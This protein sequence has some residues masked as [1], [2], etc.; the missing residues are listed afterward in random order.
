M[1][2][3]IHR[4]LIKEYTSYKTVTLFF[5]DIEGSTRLLQKLGDNYSDLLFQQKKIMEGEFNSYNGEISD[6][7]GDGFFVIFETA[8]DAVKCAVSIQQKV[9]SH[10]WPENSEV[11]IRMGI[12]TGEVKISDSGYSGI[13]IH[14]AARIMS[15][16]FGGQVL[17]SE[18]TKTL[19]EKNLSLK[20]KIKYL[21][22][23]QLKDLH[24]PEKIYQ[25]IMEGLPS[26]FPPLKSSV[27]PKTNLPPVALKLIGRE[28]EIESL[29]KFLTDKETRLVTITGPGGMG[30][31]T[32]GTKVCSELIDNFEDG[33]FMVD[34]S[35]LNDTGLVCSTIGK[36]LGL[37]ESN[38]TEHLIAFL[39]NK[40]M[41]LFLDN[42]EHLMEAS[43]IIS[44]LI[45]KCPGIKILITSRILLN[46]RIEKEFQLSPLTLPKEEDYKN[47]D[48]LRLYTSVQLFIN[49]AKRADKNFI[50]TDE[51]SE[52]IARICIR[53]DGL[54]LAIELASAR[55]KLFTPEILL[56]KLS[57]KLNILKGSDKELPERHQTLR[58]TI[59]WSYDL[60]SE[61]EKKLFEILSVFAGRCTVEAIEK[62]C[63]EYFPSEVELF[64]SVQ[65]LIDK[66]LL[67]RSDEGT[68]EAEFNMLF[69]IRE[70][71]KELLIKS[72][73]YKKVKDM[74]AF[75]FLSK[76]EEAE[77]YL[78]GK[79][80]KYWSDMLDADI[81]N[82]RSA[83]AWAKKENNTDLALRLCAS[84]WRFWIIRR[85]LIEGYEIMKFILT[86]PF[87]DSQRQLRAKV[88]NGI[89]T[90]LHEIN[91]FESAYPIIEESIK[92]YKET[93]DKKGEL[94]SLINLFWVVIHLDTPGRGDEI[95]SKCLKLNE[96]IK[97]E[98]AYALIYNN[99][100][101]LNFI[102][103]DFVKARDY[104]I[105]SL[106]KRITANDKRGEGF[107][108]TNIGWVEII[109]GDF[110]KA[111]DHLKKS[112]AT[113]TELS[114]KQL[115]GWGLSIY[116][117][118]E[119]YRGNLEAADTKVMEAIAM[120]RESLH[121]WSIS[122]E[123]LLFGVIRFYMNDHKTG[124]E[125][126][127]KGLSFSRKIR[128]VWGMKRALVYLGN[129]CFETGDL[130]KS[131]SCFKEALEISARLNDKMGFVNVLEGAALLCIK[132]N[133][134][135]KAKKLYETIVNVRREIKAPMN[136]FERMTHE[137]NLLNLDVCD[138]IDVNLDEALEIA[139]KVFD[140]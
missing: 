121:E 118:L 43:D 134:N 63:G 15:A 71:S 66:S 93:E 86:M 87:K 117:F 5:S 31:T 58:Q 106:E 24:S 6:I 90:L 65:A 44:E 139:G 112:I 57:T 4:I 103:G 54:P 92:L 128:T 83:V 101:W 17:I 36:V 125:N 135:E 107:A 37:S 102:R 74:H 62:V 33:V 48:K 59:M 81:D 61:E 111:E 72:G 21:G 132:D 99:L 30:K 114:D 22:E 137:K 80:V 50:F 2:S 28:E 19:I 79:D 1:V 130:K 95:A 70:F 124:M 108:D 35:S 26:E 73:D 85:N 45:L 89:G 9:Y 49:R 84:L 18:T 126:I 98:R 7:S 25:L 78:T 41:L 129:I 133:E 13:D 69:T 10:R 52:A 123:T 46:L 75:Y 8:S 131:K 77:P 27:A 120:M 104:Y 140:S 113:M 138:I 68:A 42:F 116:S 64:D 110:E 3:L 11:R 122:F 97:D 40:N 94:Y 105:K 109:M 23:Y 38:K 56:S 67:R 100:G 16:G 60:L 20:V 53:L 76:S 91:D 14:R 12:H 55:I 39:E 127:E 34:L 88:L 51:N 119:F 115:L 47:P 82:Y 96:S 32:I 136:Y 29:K